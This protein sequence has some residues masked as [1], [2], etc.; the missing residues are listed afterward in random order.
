MLTS[1][2]RLLAVAAANGIK[3]IPTANVKV[4]M[5]FDGTSGST[6]ITD[7][8]GNALTVRSGIALTNTTSKF[9]GT[10]GSFD[11]ASGH[12][13]SSTSQIPGLAFGTGDFCIEGFVN[14]NVLGG[15]G[16]TRGV[17]QISTSSTGL[18]SSFANTLALD[19]RTLDTQWE[20][21]ANNGQPSSAVPVTG[22]W[23][24]FAVQRVSGTTKL[25]IDGVPVISIADTQNYTGTYL[26]VGGLYDL[27][28]MLNGYID[29]FRI[30]NIAVYPTGGFTVPTAPFPN[31]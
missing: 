15:G 18:Q 1:G 26:S 3:R 4:L 11:G 5:H 8:R 27:P 10:S 12:Y 28:H 7:E 31:S 24:H 2:S 17:F 13:I 6:A 9:G 30:C 23:Y 21:Y 25:F 22:Q 20:I 19:S 14:F 16:I 29:E